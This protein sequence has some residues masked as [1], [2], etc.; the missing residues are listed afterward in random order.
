[1]TRWP[2]REDVEE[3]LKNIEHGDWTRL[4]PK[5]AP[6]VDR[7]KFD[8]CKSFIIY[9]RENNLKQKDLAQMLDIDPALMSKILHYHID[10]FTI[11]RLVRFL[12]IL[13]KDISINI[14]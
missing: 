6:T 3:V 7:I 12:D 4:L 11:D 8:L 5:D 10:E 9:M 1:M 14:A 2:K 13:H